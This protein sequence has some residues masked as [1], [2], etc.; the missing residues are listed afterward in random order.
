MDREDR[1]PPLRERLSLKNPVCL[2]LDISDP[3]RGLALLRKTGPMAGMVKAGPVPF[4]AWGETLLRTAEKSNIPLFLDFKW[5]DIPNT[6]HETILHLP[7][8]AIR[9]VTVH[10]MGGPTMIRAARE[11]CQ[12]LGPNRPVLLAVT[13]LTH[14]T[15]EEL[16][17]I[18]LDDGREVAVKR[19]GSMA[20]EAGADGLV[21]SPRELLFARSLWGRGP[22]LVTPGIRP[23]GSKV[24]NDDQTNVETPG[25]ALR[26]GA[27]LLVVGRPV[28]QAEDPVGALAGILREIENP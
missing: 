21:L 14:L 27:D 6:V 24:E 7:S 5:H 20:L 19:L 4:L 26:R 28:L 23:K 25:E 12:K 9:M 15:P 22:Y 16:G 18:G 10:A 13:A 17:A 8:P 3:V 11:A 2:S 1:E